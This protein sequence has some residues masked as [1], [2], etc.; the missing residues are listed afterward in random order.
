MT[1]AEWIGFFLVGWGVLFTFYLIVQILA[2]CFFK[3]RA[4]IAAAV[5][6]VLMIFVLFATATAYRQGSNL[7][8]MLLILCSPIATFFIAVVWLLQKSKTPSS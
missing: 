3:G 4:K 2:V 7:W 5:P 6:I 8:P 1:L